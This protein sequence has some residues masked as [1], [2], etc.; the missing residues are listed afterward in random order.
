MIKNKIL[1]LIS[2]SGCGKNYVLDYLLSNYNYKSLVSHTTRDKR[3]KEI[4]HVDYHFI[5]TEEF[6][7]MIKNEKL[8]E[9]RIYET[10][11]N[12]IP[13]IW[14][15]GLSKQTVD[16]LNSNTNYVTIFDVQGAKEFVEYYGRDNCF[17]CMLKCDDKIREE[18]AKLRGGW[19]NFEWQRRLASDKVIFSDDNTKGLIDHYITNDGTIEELEIKIKKL[20]DKLMNK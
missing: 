19:D 2:P 11:V 7:Y 1:I 9:Y 8:V 6:L 14:H 18:R 16:D 15:Y 12:N 17:V 4:D 5:S 20:V 13:S 3:P 10:L